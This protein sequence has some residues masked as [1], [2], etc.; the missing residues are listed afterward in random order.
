MSRWITIDEIVQMLDIDQDDVEVWGHG[1]TCPN[2]MPPH[3]DD[4][5]IEITFPEIKRLYKKYK[6]SSSLTRW[7]RYRTLYRY[8]V[9]HYKCCLK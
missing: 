1:S 6:D 5:D 8:A 3:F 4:G 7:Y 9:R 2:K